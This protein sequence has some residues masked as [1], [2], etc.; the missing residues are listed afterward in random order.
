MD[1]YDVE[2]LLYSSLIYKQFTTTYLHGVFIPIIQNCYGP[3]SLVGMGIESW[4]GRD[5]SH[6]S[7]PTLGL[8]QPPVQWVPS[9][10]RG[11][12]RP[13]RDADPSPLLVPW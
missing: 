7:E 10:S 11:K 3:G 5:F 1:V 13:E 8:T 2:H 4:W 12:E 9:L 6:L